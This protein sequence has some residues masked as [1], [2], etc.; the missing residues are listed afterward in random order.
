VL[1]ISIYFTSFYHYLLFHNIIELIGIMM[2]LAIFLVFWNSRK[3]IDNQ[4][5]TLL[6]LSFFF[7]G[8][9]DLIHTLSYKG[10]NIFLGYDANLPT[11][12]WVAGR[13]F[14]AITLLLSVLFIGKKLN[15]SAVW[16]V[17]G[18]VTAALLTLVFT[19]YFPDCYSE[20][21]GLTTFKIVSEF[22]ICMIYAS[23][24]VMLYFKRSNF[25]STTLYFISAAISFA[26]L[27]EVFFSL[28]FDVTG[29]FNILGH[30]SRFI[31]IYFFY[32]ATV[33]VGLKNPLEL[34]FQNLQSQHSQRLHSLIENIPEG[35][36]LLDEDHNVII[37]NPAATE[38]L[39]YL[40]KDVKVNKILN[41]IDY[42]IEEILNPS[43][44]DL[45]YYEIHIESPDAR[46]FHVGGMKITQGAQS[47]DSILVIHDITSQNKI[48]ERVQTQEK[49]A[50]IG[51]LARGISHDFK[52]I[53][54]TISGAAELI[55]T[56]SK[57]ESLKNLG[58][59]I[60]EQTA[61]GTEL[62]NQIL[63]FSGQSKV[64]EEVLN[65]KP[66]I[67]ETV[68]LASSSLPVNISIDTTIDDFKI[69]INKI[70]LQQILLN[71]IVN[72]KDALKQGG[73]IQ[74]ST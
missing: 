3:A 50:S 35:I 23:S 25:G 64:Q 46:V 34:L 1:T 10:M 42:S 48:R 4:F 71:L 14:Q 33:R 16:I 56:Q 45:T 40:L 72:S 55:E 68:R 30:I 51:K 15:V 74:I 61:K 47:G 24:I 69:R 60:L 6:G 17:L 41:I 2:T 18:A 57:D 8:V 28:Y 36:V 58:N 43:G 73:K 26:I 20:H 59:M 13:A 19:G 70:Q 5:F 39:P 67:E 38:F 62:I 21:Y 22:V 52:N 9:I 37:K 54:W 66:V 44:S 49:L 12:L 29:T 63:D 31:S 27:G 53:I 65:V 11:Q 7:I 32:R